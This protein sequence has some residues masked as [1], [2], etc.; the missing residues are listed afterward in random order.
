MR[1]LASAR[2]VGP[3]NSITVHASG[4]RSL[5]LGIGPVTFDDG[6]AGHLASSDV[7]MLMPCSV[8]STSKLPPP[9]GLCRVQVTS[10]P[11]AYVP[12]GQEIVSEVGLNTPSSRTLLSTI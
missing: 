5:P 10:A 9:L 3:S 2:S 6:L 12:G 8:T 7:L 4:S 11:T 1:S